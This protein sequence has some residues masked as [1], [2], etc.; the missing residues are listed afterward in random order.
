[1]P[2]ADPPVWASIFIAGFIAG[3]AFAIGLETGIEPDEVSIGIFVL[4]RI[5]EITENQ[6]SQI[7]YNCQA[8]LLIA[9]VISIIAAIYAVFIQAV[10]M[11]DWRIGLAIYAFGWI[12]GFVVLMSSL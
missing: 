5:C 6:D 10:R 8:V 12:V 2:A 9:I 3:M 7:L 1:M 11:N 4:E